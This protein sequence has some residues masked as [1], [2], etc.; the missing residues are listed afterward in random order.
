MPTL[1]K[2]CKSVELAYLRLMRSVQADSWA[3]VPWEKVLGATLVR[4]IPFN[5]AVLVTKSSK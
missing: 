4:I 5:R 1:S 3:K 2:G